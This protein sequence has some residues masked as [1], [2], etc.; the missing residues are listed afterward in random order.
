[1]NHH[2]SSTVKPLREEIADSGHDPLEDITRSLLKQ[3]G[4]DPEREG[5]LRTP[6]RVARAWR[7]LTRGYDQDINSIINK[8]IFE[9]TCD[10]MV[11]VTNI[12]FFSLCE[13]HLLP[14]FGT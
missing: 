3:I 2:S 9:E 7:F 12:D 8:A 10:E 13:H 11:V 4:E 5:L 6:G 14:F 1:M